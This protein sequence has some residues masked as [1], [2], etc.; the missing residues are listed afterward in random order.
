MLVIATFTYFV[1]GASFHAGQHVQGSDIDH[2]MTCK[3]LSGSRG[4]DDWKHAL[5]CMTAR[6]GCS[7]RVEP[8]YEVGTASP[9]RAGSRVDIEAKLPLPHGPSLLD[10]SLT[11][12]RAA[13]YVALSR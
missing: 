7:N 13:T 4:L 8:G 11:H 3:K 6:A 2:V 9:G 5:S 10:V 12:P 1:N